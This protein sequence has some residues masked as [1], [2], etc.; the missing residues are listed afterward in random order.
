MKKTLR[1]KTHALPAPV[2]PPTGERWNIVQ[3]ASY[4]GLPYQKARNNMMANLYG[5]S[6]YIAETRSLTVLSDGV[7]A[8]KRTRKKRT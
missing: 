5:P 1:E 2:I 8:A 3:V 6:V 7:I 4:L